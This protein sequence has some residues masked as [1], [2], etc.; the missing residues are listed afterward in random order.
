MGV[1][2]QP[3]LEHGVQVYHEGLAGLQRPPGSR[4]ARAG[5]QPGAIPGGDL[6]AA[7][8]GPLPLAP[9]LAHGVRRQPGDLGL[10]HA[11]VAAVHDGVVDGL[12]AHVDDAGGLAEVVD[13]ALVRDQRQAIH[14]VV[15]VDEPGTGQ[16]SRQAFVLVLCQ[17]ALGEVGGHAA[18][19]A[20]RALAAL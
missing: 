11:L 4:R 12:V 2:A 3:Q 13:R 18:L 5:G 7:G 14:D 20:D 17:V 16:G 1:V 10:G 15:G 6:V 19:H 8:E 9:C